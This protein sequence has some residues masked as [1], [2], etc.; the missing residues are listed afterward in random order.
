MYLQQQRL[1]GFAI[2][3]ERLCVWMRAQMEV[4]RLVRLGA[5]T[6]QKII[7]QHAMEV[8]QIFQLLVAG[9]IWL[10][11]GI[12]LLKEVQQNQRQLVQEL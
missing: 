11:E 9:G 6:F 1:I 4:I 5:I 12:V 7:R 3:F 10:E 8:K 2:L